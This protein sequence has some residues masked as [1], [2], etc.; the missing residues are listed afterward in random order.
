MGPEVTLVTSVKLAKLIF[1]FFGP[2]M[3]RK[4]KNI[5]FN[6]PVEQRLL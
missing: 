6:S 5:S 4:F 3:T 1:V 2:L